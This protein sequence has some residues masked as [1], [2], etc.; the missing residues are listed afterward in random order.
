MTIR[1]QSPG[2]LRKA[3]DALQP[4]IAVTFR[5]AMK[6]ALDPLPPARCVGDGVYV[7]E[8]WLDNEKFGSGQ[9]D[10]IATLGRKWV[11]VV[12]LATGESAKIGMKDFL[13]AVR[14]P[15]PTRNLRELK[16]ARVAKRLRRNA[17][18][19]GNL[20]TAAVKDALKALRSTPRKET[21]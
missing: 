20:D 9:R 5:E 6:A 19:F 8:L 3:L 21:T 17:A 14:G 11:R 18:T 16:P 4:K 1:V 15:S 7:L 13:A 12:E 10:F 2:P